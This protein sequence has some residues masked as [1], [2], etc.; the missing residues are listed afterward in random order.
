M[1]TFIFKTFAIFSTLVVIPD[2]IT[3]VVQEMKNSLKPEQQFSM[4]NIL[5]SEQYLTVKTTSQFGTSIL[6]REIETII[7]VQTPLKNIF[8]SQS[9]PL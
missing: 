3:L 8:F 4:C 2:I 7:H 1:F 6:F 5:H 9:I